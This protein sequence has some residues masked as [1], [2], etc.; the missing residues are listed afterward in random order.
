MTGNFENNYQA[1][2][3]EAASI[4]ERN[5]LR[6]MLRLWTKDA[7]SSRMANLYSII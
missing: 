3:N 1:I 2:I 7:F 5:T 4:C 6:W